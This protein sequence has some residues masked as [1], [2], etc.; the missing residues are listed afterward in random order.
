MLTSSFVGMKVG[1]SK[2]VKG[3]S[4]AVSGVLGLDMQYD[5]SFFATEND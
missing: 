4:K 2:L 1:K 3:S 5:Q